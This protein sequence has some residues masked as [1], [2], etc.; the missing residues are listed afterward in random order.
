YLDEESGQFTN[1][2]GDRD[3]GVIAVKY[4]E[5]FMR[6]VDEQGNETSPTEYVNHTNA[7]SFLHFGKDPAGLD[8]RLPDTIYT[9]NVDG[10]EA[11]RVI[12]NPSITHPWSHFSKRSTTATIEFFDTAFGSPK[13]IPANNQVWQVKEFFN[14]VGLIGFAMFIVTFAKSMLNTQFFSSLRTDERVA[15]IKLSSGSGKAWFWVLQLASVAFGTLIYIPLLTGV[16]SFTMAKDPWPQSQ[17]WGIG[18][19]AFWC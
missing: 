9:E 10:N 12:Y 1:V 7:Q 19:W 5:F 8:K 6:D 4:E 2:Y 16:N 17:T 14:L 13:A 18:L 3:V 15:P 11:I